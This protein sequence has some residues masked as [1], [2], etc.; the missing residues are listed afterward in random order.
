MAVGSDKNISC[1]HGHAPKGLTLYFCREECPEGIQ[2]KEDT[3][4]PYVY[5]PTKATGP[6]SV[7]IPY[8]AEEQHLKETIASVDFTAHGDIEILPICDADAKGIRWAYNTG[9][10]KAEHDVLFFLDAHCIVGT[11]GWDALLQEGLSGSSISVCTL[12]SIDERAW[13]L[14]AKFYGYADIDTK[15]KTSLLI[16]RPWWF[17]GQEH[18]P[19]PAFT[20]CGWMI[21]KRDYWAWGG[22]DEGLGEWGAVGAEWTLKAWSQGN[23][24][25]VAAH[26]YLGH[27]FRKKFPYRM[28]RWSGRNS[29]LLRRYKQDWGELRDRMNATC[30]LSSPSRERER[31]ELLI[32]LPKGFQLA[33]NLQRHLREIA[34]HY[35]KTHRIKTSEDWQTKRL[36]ICTQ[37]P[38]GKSVTDDSG[39]LRCALQSCG[40]YLNNPNGRPLLGG[41]IEYE[42]LTCDNGHWSEVDKSYAEALG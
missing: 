19:S 6:V 39:V 42:A 1:R 33:Q 29:E 13:K 26:A 18:Y 38:D 5:V 35:T 12:V 9:A 24:V 41:K 23:G 32:Q 11:H 21:P 37:C 16:G 22:S 27:L 36:G 20:G 40:C 8:R 7:I 17:E 14:R 28:K 2:P 15:A 30:Y 3:I 34:T 10:R 4:E 25:S 31:E